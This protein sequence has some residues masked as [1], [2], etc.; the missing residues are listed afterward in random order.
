M[1]TDNYFTSLKLAEELMT[2]KITILGTTRKQRREVPN[3]KSLMKD[4][5][6]YDSVTFSSPSDCS[7]TVYNKENRLHLGFKAQTRKS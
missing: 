2:K 6:L 4:K 1:T 7:L 5:L 3:T